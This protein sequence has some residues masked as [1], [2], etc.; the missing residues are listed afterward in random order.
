MQDIEFDLWS[1]ESER[2]GFNKKTF[3]D[4]PNEVIGNIPNR[5]YMN[6]TYKDK[7]GWSTGHLLNFSIGQGEVWIYSYSGNSIN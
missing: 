1:K 6:K 2:L 7:G 5:K 4:L 3:V